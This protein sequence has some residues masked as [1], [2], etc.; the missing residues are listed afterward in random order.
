MDAWQEIDTL[1]K[2][3]ALDQ[4]AIVQGYRHGLGGFTD[5]T[6]IDQ[7]YWY[8]HG[9]ACSDRQG[10]STQ[11]QQQIAREYVEEIRRKVD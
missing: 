5:H 7:S 1:A 10:T 3:N 2:V 6:R 8:G 9:N 11:A 4:D